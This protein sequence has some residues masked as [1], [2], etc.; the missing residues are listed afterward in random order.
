MHNLRLS[1]KAVGGARELVVRREGA[2]TQTRILEPRLKVVCERTK[3]LQA[4]VRDSCMHGVL[5]VQLLCV[6]S[7]M[8]NT[9]LILY[10]GFLILVNK[11]RQESWP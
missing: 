11:V 9:T 10:W 4:Q 6:R 7:C 8:Q 3:L 5:L 2:E 1:N